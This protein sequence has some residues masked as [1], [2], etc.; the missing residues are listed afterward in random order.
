M[1]ILYFLQAIVLL[2]YFLELGYAYTVLIE[3]KVQLH[4]FLE[5][6]SIEATVLLY[7]F[8]ELGYVYTVLHRGYSTTTLLPRVR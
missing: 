8:L 6:D 4:Y 5:L 7:Y 2:H 1:S 3:K